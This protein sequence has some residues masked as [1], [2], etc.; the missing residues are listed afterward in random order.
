MTATSKYLTEQYPAADFNF[1]YLQALR[2]EENPAHCGLFIPASQLDKC[3]WQNIDA[4]QI[5]EYTYNSGDREPG[6]LLKNP[7]MVITPISKL[8]AF[9]RSLS[10][11]EGTLVIL[12]EWKQEHK[13]DP[14]IG[15][16]QVYL[17]MFVNEKN[18]PLHDV[19]LKLVAKGAFQASLSENYQKF[20]TQ[21]ARLRAKSQGIPFRPQN[22]VFNALCVFSPI[23]KRQ[24]VG[25]TIKS[26]SCYVSGYTEP[27]LHN[28]LSFFLGANEAVADEIIDTLNPQPRLLLPTPGD[29]MVE[30]PQLDR[31]TPPKSIPAI[32]V[33]STLVEEEEDV[34][35]TLTRG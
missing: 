22:E 32:D 34:T 24:M 17:V 35:I 27:T 2:G 25:T 23:F 28:W 31:S 19:P 8:G 26:A 15:N 12:G 30:I 21:M 4:N 16:F 1:P 20:C 29:R 11:K 9:D 3:G 13:T 10:Q 33:V 6:L 14:N 5:V 7:R 18:E